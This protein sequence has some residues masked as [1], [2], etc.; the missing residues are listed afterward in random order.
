M[1]DPCTIKIVNFVLSS[2]ISLSPLLP[3][4]PSLP[5]SESYSGGYNGL[6]AGGQV[7]PEKNFWRGT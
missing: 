2:L 1:A 6:G 7:K 3:L 4:S 5:L